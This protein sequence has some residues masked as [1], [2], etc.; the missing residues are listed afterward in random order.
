MRE[1]N[2]ITNWYQSN[3]QERPTREALVKKLEL[4][5]G[6]EKSF[7]LLSVAD[8]YIDLAMRDPDRSLEHLEA[9]RVLLGTIIERA[10][11]ARL[12]KNITDY[13]NLFHCAAYA[14]FR[15]SEVMLWQQA[16]LGEEMT[17]AF[18]ERFAAL[19]LSEKFKA[20]VD[21]QSAQLEYIIPFLGSFALWQQKEFGYIGRQSLVREG[22]FE[23]GKSE[24]TF[25]KTNWDCA[26]FLDGPVYDPDR[27][28]RKIEI[29]RSRSKTGSK[30]RVN[31]KYY[32][33]AGTR[34]IYANRYELTN[35]PLIIG[36]VDAELLEA[37][38]ITTPSPLLAKGSK[39]LDKRT[40]QIYSLARRPVKPSDYSPHNQM[41]DDNS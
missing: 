19:R 5:Q 37:T 35:I 9:C 30:K 4:V 34:L 20:S 2:G 21:A 16:A 26:V 17:S 14:V 27:P 23:D 28:T 31:A 15:Q 3:G 40:R 1:K 32:A 7:T 33:E 38:T 41:R 36:I 24:K 11:R 8:M 6:K 12:E 39:M 25:N 18:P 13:P 22:T 29:K 10:L